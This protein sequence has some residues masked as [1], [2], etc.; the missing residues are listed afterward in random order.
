[1]RVQPVGITENEYRCE[2]QRRVKA[3][4]KELSRRVEVPKLSIVILI[5]IVTGL[6]NKTIK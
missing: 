5:R 2:R 6:R 4:G 1:M 3:Q